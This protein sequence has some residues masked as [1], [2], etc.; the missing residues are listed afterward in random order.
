[1]DLEI[2][3]E[4]SV[5]KCI[6]Y[7]GEGLSARVY[8]AIREDSRGLAQQNVAIK[9][10][11]S[12][13][14]I[15]WMRQEFASLAKVQSLHCVRLLS[16]ENTNLGSALVLE[17]IEGVSLLELAREKAL[18]EICIEEVA[19]QVYEGLT[20]LHDNGLFHGDLSPSNILIDHKGY[21]KL[22]DFAGS[23]GGAGWVQGTP[24]YL[25]PEAWA[26]SG[27]SFHSD[28]FSLGLI[29]HDLQHQFLTV[30]RT[31]SECQARAQ[32]MA[33]TRKGLFHADPV[34]RQPPRWS[35]VKGA[36]SDMAAR[37]LKIIRQREGNSLRTARMPSVSFTCD[38]KTSRPL[39][40]SVR[41]SILHLAPRACAAIGLVLG[42]V[43]SAAGPRLRHY[44]IDKMGSVW[45]TS[46]RWIEISLDGH[47]VGYSPLRIDK[48]SA[49]NHIL[50]WRSSSKSGEIR[51]HVKPGVKVLI[52][53]SHLFT[54]SQR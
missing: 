23:S 3:P 51:I 16:W 28:L 7:V 20:D 47:P 31:Q 26:G 24:A 10:L 30:P 39:Q 44:N 4:Q 45:I 41:A 17:W 50:K 1:M 11:K 19:R 38:S 27:G 36:R 46:N 34:L 12:E 9:L 49:G 48:V 54:P 5:Y 35:N 25:S 6:S 53:E 2:R 14:S 22:V 18:D 40:K 32:L 8:K 43:T 15:S 21:V 42:L 13:T 37:V 29:L 52:N 33:Q